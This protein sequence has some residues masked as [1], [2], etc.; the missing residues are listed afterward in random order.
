[1]AGDRRIAAGANFDGVIAYVQDDGDRGYLSQ[2]A[3]D[4]LDRPF[5]LVGK[6]GNTRRTVP[7]WDAL[8]RNSTGPRHGLTLR[9]AQ[10]ATYTDAEPMVPQIVRVLHL[11]G[12]IAAATI[13]TVDP[14]HAITAERALLAAFFDRYLRGRDD[15]GLLERPGPRY[16]EVRPFS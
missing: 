2:V 1:M 13:G 6:D 7:S 9:G 3:A 10:H 14:R 5:L 16:P 11:P 12:G 8:W 15:R 4:G